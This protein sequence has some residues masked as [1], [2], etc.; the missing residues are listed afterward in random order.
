MRDHARE[1]RDDASAIVKDEG[2]CTLLKY[3]DADGVNVLYSPEFGYAYVNEK[4]PGVGNSLFLEIDEVTS[5]EQ[6]AE[7]WNAS[8]D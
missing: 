3:H 7:M 8:N 6:A 5:V 1:C 4:S 2:D